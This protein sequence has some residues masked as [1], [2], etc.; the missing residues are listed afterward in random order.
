M[1]RCVIDGKQC[2]CQPSDGQP[3]TFGTP[4]AVQAALNSE[5]MALRA[6][7]TALQGQPVAWAT[8]EEIRRMRQNKYYEYDMPLY[9][10]TNKEQVTLPESTCPYC[11][12]ADSFGQTYYDQ[13]CF[14]CVERMGDK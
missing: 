4:A 1:T 7:L 5:I 2:Q 6:E 3:C 11:K 10:A 8:P 12:M 13:N 9:L 14:G